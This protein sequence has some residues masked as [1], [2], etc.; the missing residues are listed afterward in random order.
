M[1]GETVQQDASSRLFPISGEDFGMGDRNNNLNADWF[2]HR[3]HAADIVEPN[4]RPLHF[5]RLPRR[6]IQTRSLAQTPIDGFLIVLGIVNDCSRSLMVKCG[7]HRQKI[8]PGLAPIVPA[9]ASAMLLA[10]SVR[11]TWCVGPLLVI[12]SRESGVR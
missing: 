6:G 2:L 9:T 10:Q 12:R 5:L 8:V 4:L 3:F 11:C 7:P 1:A